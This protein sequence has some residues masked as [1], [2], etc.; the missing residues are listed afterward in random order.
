MGWDNEQF[1]V[2]APAAPTLNQLITLFDTT[3]MFGGEA[4]NAIAVMGLSRVAVTFSQV[5]QASQALGLVPSSST[6]GGVNWDQTEAGLTV[7]ASV[8]GSVFSHDYVIDVFKDFR[9]R[10]Q[11]GTAPTTWRVSIKVICGQRMVST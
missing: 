6:D 8:A 10:Y 4:C 5:D 2:A 11:A 7:P 3:T 1:T 9:I